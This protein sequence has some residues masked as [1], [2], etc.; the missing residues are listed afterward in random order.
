MILR[1]LTTPKDKLDDD[2]A[3]LSKLP[4]LK[5]RTLVVDAWKN[6]TLLGVQAPDYEAAKR[7]VT[8]A[9]SKARLTCR[10]PQVQRSVVLNP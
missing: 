5:G 6:G 4:E 7:I 8:A 1:S 10:E 3:A 2:V 9:G